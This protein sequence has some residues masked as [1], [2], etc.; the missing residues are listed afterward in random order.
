MRRYGWLMVVALMSADAARASWAD[1]LFEELSR[2]FGS[3][4]RGQV[5]T[6]PF[7]LVNTTKQPIHIAG[8]RVSCSACT[9]AR[10]LQ[11]TLA[12][13]QE[14]AVLVQRMVNSTNGVGGLVTEVQIVP[15]DMGDN[16]TSELSNATTPTLA[17]TMNWGTINCHFLRVK[18]LYLLVTT[19]FAWSSSGQATLQLYVGRTSANAAPA[20]SSARTPTKRTSGTHQPWSV[21]GSN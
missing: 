7:R 5:L 20:V 4:P 15:T 6:H 3:V 2:D 13:G 14:T 8:V 10:A 18:T 19:A 9:S 17:A 11:T 12:P 16:V 1:A 21:T